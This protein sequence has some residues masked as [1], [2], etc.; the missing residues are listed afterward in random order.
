MSGRLI[1]SLGHFF[2]MA[3]SGRGQAGVMLKI[4]K[5]Q[6]ARPRLIPAM[7]NVVGIEEAGARS[8]SLL[9]LESTTACPLPYSCSSLSLHVFAELASSAIGPA[10]DWDKTMPNTRRPATNIPSKRCTLSV[11]T[12]S[13]TERF[14]STMHTR[15]SFRENS[16]IRIAQSQSRRVHDLTIPLRW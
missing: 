2:G 6:R 7:A 1:Q 14:G 5:R 15:M 11:R 13:G 10:G 9:Q 4:R 3:Q 12:S 8:L 16:T